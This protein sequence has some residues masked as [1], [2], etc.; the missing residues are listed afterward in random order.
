MTWPVAVA[1]VV[2]ERGD[3]RQVRIDVGARLRSMWR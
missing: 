1:A 3:P 2:S